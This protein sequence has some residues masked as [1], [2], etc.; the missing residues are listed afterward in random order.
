MSDDVKKII[1]MKYVYPSFDH[2]DAWVGV[3]F[4]KSLEGAEVGELGAAAIG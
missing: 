4:E 1:D 3:L 2:F